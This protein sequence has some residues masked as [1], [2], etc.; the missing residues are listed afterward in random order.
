[1]WDAERL[2]IIEEERDDRMSVMLKEKSGDAGV[3]DA[4]RFRI[5]RPLRW[6]CC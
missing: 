4:Q 1:M 2:Q 5:G 6:S 3:G